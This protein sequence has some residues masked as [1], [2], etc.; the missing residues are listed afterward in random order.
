MAIKFSHYTKMH[1][2][3][4][5]AAGIVVIAGLKIGAP[6]INPILM[7]V[8]FSVI[9]YHPIDWLKKKGVNGVLSILIVVLGLLMVLF[10][11]GGAV[12]RSI[13]QFSH[14]LPYYKTQLHEITSSSITLLNGY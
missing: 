14:N 7:A 12:T 6:I 10:L 1:P 4:Y 2:L 8:F 13:I 3:F 5:I 9:I 11:M